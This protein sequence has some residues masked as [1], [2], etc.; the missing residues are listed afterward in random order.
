FMNQSYQCNKMYKILIR[1]VLITENGDK[2]SSRHGQK[3][4]VGLLVNHE[5]LPY[6]ADG[7]IPDVLINPQAFPSRMTVGMFLESVTGKA[8]ALRGTK[9]DGSAFVGEK[10]EDVK[11]VL[12]SA[13]FKYSG[14]E[15]MYD[16]RT[17]KAF[18]AEVFIGVVYYQ[19]LHHMV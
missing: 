15:M 18:P 6:T 8:A 9:M 12:E 2:F 14:K 3:C 10:L 7:V 17:G 16:G 13:G 1:N 19:K 4:V 11:G 5:D